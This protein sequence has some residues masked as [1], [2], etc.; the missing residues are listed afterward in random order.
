MPEIITQLITKVKKNNN[1]NADKEIIAVATVKN[2]VC[3]MGYFKHPRVTAQPVIFKCH[4]LLF[5]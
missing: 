4:T 3:H 2:P 1:N 5:E